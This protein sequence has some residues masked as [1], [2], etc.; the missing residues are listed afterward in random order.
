VNSLL[1]F[2][3]YPGNMIDDY[4]SQ[5]GTIPTTA[6]HPTLS[7]KSSVVSIWAVI[8]LRWKLRVPDKGMS[9]DQGQ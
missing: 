3:H 5:H 9:V 7:I 6:R 4:L 1:E 2:G 8:D